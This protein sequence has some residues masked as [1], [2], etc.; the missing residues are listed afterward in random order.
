MS[1]REAQV[2]RLLDAYQAQRAESL[3]GRRDGPESR[4]ASARFGAARRNASGEE[5][6][7]FTDRSLDHVLG[8]GWRD[9]PGAREGR[10][11]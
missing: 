5:F 2:Q 3:A 1:K 9:G 4:Q 7:E 11:R 8:P 6:A 10:S